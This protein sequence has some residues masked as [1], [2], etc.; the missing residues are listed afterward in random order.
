MR[1]PHLALFTQ[2][3][4]AGCAMVEP[5]SIHV[6]QHTTDAIFHLKLQTSI[7]ELRSFLCLRKTFRR[8]HPLSHALQ[9]PWTE[10]GRKMN[11]WNSKRLLK[12]NALP[13]NSAIGADHTTSVVNAPINMY[14]IPGYWP[15]QWHSWLCSS[16][17]TGR[18]TRQYNS[19]LVEI[20][21][22]RWTRLWLYT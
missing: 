16:R 8:F 5:F 10:N 7:T 13:T 4:D 17:I 18:R 21:Q 2:E 6:S 22:W 11:Q 15:R 9:H 20:P 14:L 3:A 12:T 19:V 1:N